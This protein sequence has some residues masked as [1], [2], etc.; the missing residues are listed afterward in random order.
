MNLTPKWGISFNGGYDFQARKITPGV[1][2]INRDLHCWQMNFS[3]VPV[4]FRKSWSF[5]IGV[6]SAMLQDIKWDKRS[7]FYDNLY[8]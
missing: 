3:W 6:K 5:N 2:T 1:I 7:S 8:D 4:G